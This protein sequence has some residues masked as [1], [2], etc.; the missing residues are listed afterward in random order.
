M[1]MGYKIVLDTPK[2]RII[3]Y[4]NNADCDL[5]YRM[6]HMFDKQLNSKYLSDYSIE[7]GGF[8]TEYFG[9]VFIQK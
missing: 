7:F 5:M 9:Q 2:A 1:K 8:S 3:Y 4:L 6:E